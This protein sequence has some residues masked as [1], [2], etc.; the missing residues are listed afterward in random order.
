[1]ISVTE[2]QTAIFQRIEQYNHSDNS[3]SQRATLTL[4]LLQ[5]LGHI[6]AVDS[7]APFDV[8]R[9]PLS[10]MDGF[11][12]NFANSDVT[13]AFNVIGESCAGKPFLGKLQPNQAVRIFTGAVVPADCDTVVIQENTDFNLHNNLALNKGTKGYT[14]LISVP[15]T[16]QAGKNIRQQGEEIRQDDIVLPKGKRLNPT[17]ITLLA[18]LGFSEVQ[19][20]ASLMVGILATGDELI[21][22]GEKLPT[23]AHIYNGNTP[24]LQALL[25]KMPIVIKDYGIIPDDLVA[26]RNAVAQAI[27][28]CDVILSSAGV[29]VGDY[30]FLTTVVSELGQINQYKVAMKPGK[31]FVF[32]EF[33]KAQTPQPTQGSKSV[34]YFGLPGNPLS[35]VVGC[36][37]FIVP[38][39]WQ[40]T[41]ASDS[42]IPTPLLLNAT[43]TADIKKVAGRQDYQRAIMS[44]VNG[45]IQVVPLAS[46]D[47]HRI[48]QLSIANCFLIL[49]SE[50]TGANAGDMVVVQPFPWAFG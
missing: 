16:C 29:S 23:P 24:S 9:Q 33:S 5:S 4:P 38:A 30:D 46:Q 40:M 2:L 44:K 18:N 27:S 45:E 19:V 32:G 47:S 14:F 17:D 42:E 28:E 25:A 31:P 26:T 15:I 49:A 48:R 21:E 10:A 37:Q 36:M 7:V 22:L 20:F 34:L 1:M 11:A 6:L 43:L 8:P 39:L 12:F 35:A 13:Q 50:S 41:G 3:L